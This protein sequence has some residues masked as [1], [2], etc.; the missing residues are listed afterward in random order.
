MGCTHS[1]YQRETHARYQSW[2]VPCLLVDFRDLQLR[3]VAQATS[4]AAI[5]TDPN[6]FMRAAAD[7]M[8]LTG[9]D[10]KPWHLR[11]KYQ[12]FNL[13][14][15]MKHGGVFEEWWDNANRHKISF[16]SAAFEQTYYRVGEDT[17]T[18]GRQGFPLFPR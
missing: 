17:L 10:M 9:A 8:S 3:C 4:T 15:S 1:L 11:V 16:T 18:S 14:G 5:A 2:I 12:T 6:Q 7:A 13:D